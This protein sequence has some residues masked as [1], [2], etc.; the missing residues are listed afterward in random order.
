MAAQRDPEMPDN[1]HQSTGPPL[2]KKLKLSVSYSTEREKDPP[3]KGCTDTDDSDHDSTVA[4]PRSLITLIF[5]IDDGT[6]K[7]KTRPILHLDL[8]LPQFSDIDFDENTVELMETKDEKV[9]AELHGALAEENFSKQQLCEDIETI[10]KACETTDG[11][12]DVLEKLNEDRIMKVV[13]VKVVFKE[14]ED[15]NE[16]AN[17]QL[18]RCFPAVEPTKDEKI[19]IFRQM[20]VFYP[21]L[22]DEAIDKCYEKNLGIMKQMK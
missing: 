19:E 14:E 7:K 13:I 18:P 11:F 15:K 1:E 17:F 10:G 20:R 8:A 16:F 9:S 4:A 3:E 22:T 21:L 2:K 6:N 12:T 5:S